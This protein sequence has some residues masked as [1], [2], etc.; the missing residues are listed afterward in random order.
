MNL[1]K[2]EHLLR[3]KAKLESRILVQRVAG[4]TTGLLDLLASRDRVDTAI[5]KEREKLEVN[6]A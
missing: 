5:T 6:D 2:L 3:Q 1:S 4:D